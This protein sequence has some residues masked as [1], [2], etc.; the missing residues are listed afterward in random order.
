MATCRLNDIID[1]RIS[2][3]Q[4]DLCDKKRNYANHVIALD[5]FFYR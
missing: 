4:I 3:C 5:I 2:T 1:D